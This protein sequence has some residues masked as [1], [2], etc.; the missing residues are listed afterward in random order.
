M[1]GAILI[2]DSVEIPYLKKQKKAKPPIKFTNLWTIQPDDIKKEAKNTFFGVELPPEEMEVPDNQEAPIEAEDSEE[3]DED[4]AKFFI[5]EDERKKK[6]K[7]KKGKEQNNSE[8]ENQANEEYET[9]N[10]QE[11]VEEGKNDYEDEYNQKEQ[12]S[13]QNQESNDVE[14]DLDNIKNLDDFKK[15]A[16]L[17]IGDSKDYEQPLEINTAYKLLRQA[18]KKNHASDKTLD[19]LLSKSQPKSSKGQCKFILCL[20]NNDE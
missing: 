4:Q 7:S 13:G 19:S 11:E 6:K 18:V 3:E 16:N 12:S 17:L 10:N 14:I 9:N 2:N 5:T 15:I 1:L 20:K 8:D